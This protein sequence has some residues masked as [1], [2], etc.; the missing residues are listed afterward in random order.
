MS[1]RL[2]RQS[3]TCLLV[4]GLFHGCSTRR[5]K[6]PFSGG[7]I[8]PLPPA[9][10]TGPAAALLTNAGAFSAHVVLSNSLRTPKTI[11]GEL[12][13]ADAK[14]LFA[15]E[16]PKKNPGGAFAYVSDLVNRQG[17][18]WSEALQGYAPASL[19]A[20]PTNLIIQKEPGGLQKFD[21]HVCQS[22]EALVQMS[23]GSQA[24]L[25][26]YRAL[27]LNR[28]PLHI[29]TISNASP[30]TLTLS[31]IRP[32]A[33][34]PDVFTPP[35]DFTKYASPEVM[36]TELIMRQHNLR[37]RPAPYSSETIYDSRNRR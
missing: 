6:N 34:P 19:H 3:I 1:P 15:A 23:D 21:G 9:F 32:T 11:S 18:V 28:F 14:L 30:F 12:F 25:R 2:W 4:L 5:E 22:T 7:T 24:A 20:T 35:T 37:R 10:L 27:D 29:E 17:F 36:V 31:N 16:P 26:V 13:V 33:P 8:E